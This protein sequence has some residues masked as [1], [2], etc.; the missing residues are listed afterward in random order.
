MESILKSIPPYVHDGYSMDF[1]DNVND[2]MKCI[3]EYGFCI[4]D[5]VLSVEACEDLTDK[6]KGLFV[7]CLWV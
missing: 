3:H 7:K 4:V 6:F 1:T 2:I 5:N